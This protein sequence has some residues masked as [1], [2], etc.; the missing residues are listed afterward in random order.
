MQEWEWTSRLQQR[1]TNQ[2]LDTTGLSKSGKLKLID[3][4]LSSEALLGE[5]KSL[6]QWE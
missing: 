3:Y 4:L 1:L 6:L 2:I 5:I